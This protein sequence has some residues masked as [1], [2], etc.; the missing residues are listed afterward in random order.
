MNFDTRLFQVLSL[1]RLPLVEVFVLGSLMTLMPFF[2]HAQSKVISLGVT[3]DQCPDSVTIGSKCSDLSGFDNLGAD[4]KKMKVGDVVNQKIP[5]PELGDFEFSFKVEE[6]KGGRL[7]FVRDGLVPADRRLHATLVGY[8]DFYVGDFVTPNGDIHRLQPVFKSGYRLKSILRSTLSGGTGGEPGQVSKRASQKKLKDP[9]SNLACEREKV[10]DVLVAY[11]AKVLALNFGSDDV[12]QARIRQAIFETNQA[13]IDSAIKFEDGEVV[14]LN[15]VCVNGDAACA[16]FTKFE[17]KDDLDKDML[18]ELLQKTGNQDQKRNF[19][20]VLQ[21][22]DDLKADVVVIIVEGKSGA[23]GH[24]TVL[25]LTDDD[26]E[27]F[28][29]VHDA[30]MTGAYTFAHEIGHILGANHN[31]TNQI[32]SGNAISSPIDNLGHIE[33]TPG[34]GCNGPWATIMSDSNSC[35]ECIRVRRWSNP[36]QEFCGTKTGSKD[37]NNKKGLADNARIVARYRCGANIQ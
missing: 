29:I 5:I 2:A 9:R 18:D 37:A 11:T 28:A 4:L 21:K 19:Q 8:K 27:P 33:R 13:F 20:D 17:E 14:T 22:R 23:A 31:F 34:E 12:I 1:F 7:Y 6:T 24:A 35:R 15:Q 16:M 3:S 30:G 32:E 25:D 36:D 26:E 10:I